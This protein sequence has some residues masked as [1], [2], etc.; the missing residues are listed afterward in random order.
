ML[1]EMLSA[2]EA[3]EQIE[4]AIKCNR[5]VLGVDGFRIVPEGYEASLDLILDVSRKPITIEAAAATTIEFIRSNAAS[6]VLF[7][8]VNADAED[9]G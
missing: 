5:L 6:D 3:V 8:V 4:A 9:G 2:D 1:T 7:E